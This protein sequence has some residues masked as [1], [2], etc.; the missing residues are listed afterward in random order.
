MKT[1]ITARHRG[2][3]IVQMEAAGDIELV[4][5]QGEQIDLAGRTKV[6]LCRCGASKTTPLCDGS[7]NRTTFEAS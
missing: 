3:L 2:P 4:D 1:K 6:A 7:H 5:T